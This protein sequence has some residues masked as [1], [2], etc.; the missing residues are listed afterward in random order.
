MQELRKADFWDSAKNNSVQCQLCHRNC[1]IAEGKQ[2]F[3]GVRKNI[4]GELYSLAYG[5]T[6]TR[7]IDPI[8][9]KPFF[10]FKP[11]T[12][13]LSISTFGCN[14]AC[15]HCQNSGQSQTRAEEAIMGTPK[16]TP[17]QIVQEAIGMDAQ[18]ISYT[19]NEPTIFAEYALDTMKIA[20]EKDLYN[21]WVSNG[22][23]TRECV[24]A[25]APYLDAINIDLKGNKKFYK[26][27][28][29][30][31]DIKFVKENI[32]AFHEKKVHVEVT[33]LVVPGFNDNEKYF[34][35]AAEFV[36]GIDKKIPLHFSRFF[37]AHKMGHLPATDVQ[38]LFTAKQ[39]ALKAGVEFVYLGNLGDDESTRCP[40]CNSI[41][42]KR[43]GFSAQPIGLDEKGNCAKCGFE[44]GII[45]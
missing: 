31:I 32:H 16:S 43:I 34:K 11:G 2:G 27:V 12:Q 29:G 39:I 1:V 20:R 28:C 38:K 5:R 45:P 42:I 13:C 22:Y 44:T 36:A 24:E 23:M 17:E 30:N 4:A 21:C 25:I 6:L 33:Y 18:G 41:L 35:E 8:E 37:P 40:K 15:L 7:A 10:H 14:F 9:K 26:E 19:Y 3:C